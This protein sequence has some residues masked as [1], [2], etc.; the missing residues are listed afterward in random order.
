MSTNSDTEFLIL[1]Q[2]YEL[3]FQNS[4][5]VEKCLLEP[6]DML[7]AF[8][9][10]HNS[11]ITLFV[12][13]GMLLCFDR[14][15]AGNRELA[16]A[17]TEVRAQLKAAA[18]AGHEL[19]LHVHPHWEDTRYV[20]GEWDFSATR[21]RLDLFSDDEVDAILRS[22]FEV[23][24]ELTNSP[25]VSY[26][27]GG[28]CIEPF[29]RIAPTLNSLGVTVESSIVPGAILVDAEK[30]FDFS[31]VADQPWWFFADSPRKADESGE[32][33]ELPVTPYSVSAGFY[34]GRL[35]DRLSSG[36]RSQKVGDGVSKAIGKPEIIRR[37][38]GQS[39]VSELSVDDAKAPYL[40]EP[41]IRAM[42]RKIWHLMGH[43]K[44]LS[45]RSLD[46][47]DDFLQAIGRD[48][49]STVADVAA[50]IRSANIA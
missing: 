38:L 34:W 45:Q 17:A 6:C 7:T 50:Q 30:G 42:E 15:A 26:R 49:L 12:D 1:S 27:A 18:E 2:D 31:D 10:Q 33:L 41:G 44:L 21:Y 20:D 35:L 3:F 24:Q 40:A 16:R 46:S 37:L 25:V 19:A 9:K 28:F 8:A 32:W 43:P 36:Q 22:N 4:G 48:K 14:F 11:Q 39:R 23:I 29:S 5:T 47:L 13:A